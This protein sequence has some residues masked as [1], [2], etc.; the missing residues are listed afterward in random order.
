MNESTCPGAFDNALKVLITSYK[1]FTTS[2]ALIHKLSFTYEHRNPKNHPNLLK[3]EVVLVNAMVFASKSSPEIHKK[4][5]ENYIFSNK[6]CLK[7]VNVVFLVSNSGLVC[8]SSLL[9]L[10][11]FPPSHLVVSLYPGQ[12][13][14]SVNLTCVSE[15]FPNRFLLK[16]KGSG[17]LRLNYTLQISFRISS[18]TFGNCYSPLAL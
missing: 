7:I 17:P 11:L 1:H 10:S 8:V 14:V 6:A 5:G 3:N 13:V 2:E 12:F 4:E 9:L 18:K 16:N 15:A